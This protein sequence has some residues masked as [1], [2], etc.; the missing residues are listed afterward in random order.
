M[1]KTVID[2]VK[3]SYG[4]AL[5]N[6]G[7]MTSFYKKFMASNPAIARKF[8]GTDLEKQKEVLKMSLSMAIL[9][10]QDNVIAKHSMAKV[11]ETH[12]QSKLNISPELY[13]NWLNSLVSVI[14]ESDPEFTSELEQQWR[15]VLNHTI[16]FIKE[17]YKPQADAAT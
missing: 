8:A 10:P 7:L 5:A 15:D 3:Q 17:G 13:D 12:C 1:E 6:K 14:E 16:N 11:R 2:A 9:F 4:R